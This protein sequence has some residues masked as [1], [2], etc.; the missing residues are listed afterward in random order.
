MKHPLL[1][2][3]VLTL[4][5]NSLYSGE[6]RVYP[7]EVQL[8]GPKASQQLIV[9][10]EED[11]RIIGDQTKKAKYTSSAPQVVAVDPEGKVKAIGDGD[12]MITASIDG[13]QAST[14][15]RVSQAKST[16][17][18]S[19]RN[20]IVPIFTRSGCNSGACHGALAGKG[21]LKLSLRGYD[22]ERD[23]FVLTRQALARRVNEQEPEQSLLLKKAT[24][25]MAHGG[26]ER[27]GE[28]SVEYQ[29]LIDWIQSG[30]K[31]PTPEDAKLQRIEVFP[32]TALLKPKDTLQVLVRAWY[33]DN[34]SRDV[35]QRS[36]FG[37]SEDLVAGVNESGTVTVNGN[38]EAAIT[39]GYGTQVATIPITS[40][41]ANKIASDVFGKSPRNNFIDELVLRKLQLLN[42]PPSE[43]SNDF[44]F[45]RRLSL[46][47]MGILP[48][49]EEVNQFVKDTSKDKRT[50]LIDRLLERPEFVDYWTYKWSDM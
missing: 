48:T 8:V 29:T 17:T 37:S 20:D 7:P 12:A 41:F 28:D 39:I 21:G 23:H 31:A 1:F 38:G 18:P 11:Q 46:D 4:S 32:K 2:L 6:L 49:S 25:Q 16:P 3:F 34:S 22:P 45:I 5:T 36:R 9:V 33:S 30:A 26:G 15:V 24:R 43:Q 35:T 27:F 50:K 42:L 40:P 14:K 10:V 47:L 13:K 44:E 19:F